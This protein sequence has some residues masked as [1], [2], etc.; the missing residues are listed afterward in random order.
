MAELRPPGASLAGF[1]ERLLAAGA[2]LARIHLASCDGWW[3]SH[4]GSGRFDLEAPSGTCYLAETAAGAFIEVFREFP[5]V[6]ASDVDERELSW[7]SVPRELR[8]A[9]AT[10]SRAR[11]F[12]LTSAIHTSEDYDT[13]RRW[14][15]EFAGRDLDGVWYRCGHDPSSREVAVALFGPAGVGEEASWPA[16]TRHVPVPAEVL[17][18]V[19]ERFGVVVLPAPPK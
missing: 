7:L 13:T 10:A 15:A 9:D 11:H 6:A 12:G 3:F 2:L 16:P 4:D 19:E 5:V 8:L 1:P 14:A 18:E 17:D